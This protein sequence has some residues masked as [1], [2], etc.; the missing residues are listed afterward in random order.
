MGNAISIYIFGG[1]EQISM[2]PTGV[3]FYSPTVLFLSSPQ[4][5]LGD[6]W[7]PNAVQPPKLKTGAL[8]V[9]YRDDEGVRNSM[10]TLTQTSLEVTT[11]PPRPASIRPSPLSFL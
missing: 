10:V 8:Y 7:V 4:N 1:R 6:P 5:F 11:F 2:E 9:Q 3:D